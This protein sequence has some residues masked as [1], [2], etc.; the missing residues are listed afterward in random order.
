MHWVVAAILLG[1]RLWI[2]AT[3]RLVEA[4]VARDVGMMQLCTCKCKS[5]DVIKFI[6]LQLNLVSVIWQEQEKITLES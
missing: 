3:R 5:G 4:R 2:T 6:Y 1:T